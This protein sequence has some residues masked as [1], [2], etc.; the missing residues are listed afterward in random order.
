MMFF[1]NTIVFTQT[2]LKPMGVNLGTKDHSA[3]TA[4]HLGTPVY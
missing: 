1:M 3:I 2:L 4:M